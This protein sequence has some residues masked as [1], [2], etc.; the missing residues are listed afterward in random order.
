MMIPVEEALVLVLD[1]VAPVGG[2][3]RVPLAEAHGRVLAEDIVATRDQPPF[4]ASAMDGYAVRATEAVPGA[5]LA[6]IGESSAGARHDRPLGDSEAV[7][8]FTGAPVPEGADAILIQENGDRQGDV[9]V[10]REATAPGRFVR[11]AGLD[12][13]SGAT[14]AR[15]GERLHPG[16]LC[17]LAAA[18]RATLPLRRR[19][20]VSV[21]ATGDEL[22]PLGGAPGPDEIVASSVHGVV[23]ILRGYGANARDAGI[24]RDTMAD[25]ERTFEAATADDPDLVVTL[26]GASVG[27]HDLV[28]DALRAR[29]IAMAF[30][31]VAMRPGKPLM[32]GRER[33]ADRERLWLGLP[34]NP[35][36]SLVCA[37]LFG[38][39]LVSRFLGTRDARMWTEVE[40][41][42]ELAAND[43]RQ[44]YLRV[45]L[46]GMVATPMDRQDSSQISRFA[47]ADALLVRPPHAAVAT[48]GTR[49]RALLLHRFH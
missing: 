8:I 32:H 40:A 18:N 37:H 14:L 4:R 49:H 20:R 6:V 1:G 27:R 25:L 46:D 39:P 45:T 9:V 31:K 23:A 28:A 34:G 24:A 44:D 43:E 47:A 5:R 17:L 21:V 36:S 30:E 19:P 12:F 10:P 13:T 7:R 11:P 22:V 15:A 16:L 33:V 41:G 42:V 29:G 35:V 2:V 38:A 3:E 26:G 48:A